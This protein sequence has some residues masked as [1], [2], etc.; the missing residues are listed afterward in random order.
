[1][2]SKILFLPAMTSTNAYA[3]QLLK[4]SILP[5]GTVIYTNYQTTGRGYFGNRWESE[6]GKN[7]LVSIILNP[8]FIKPEDQ[9]Y[10]SMA[11]SLG[12]CDF[13]WSYVNECTIKWPNDIYVKNDKIAGILVDSALSGDKI[14]YTVVGIGLNVNQEKFSKSVPN[15]ISMHLISGKNFNITDCLNKL[16]TILDKRYKQLI[17][18]DREPMKREYISKLFRYNEWTNFLDINGSF[19]GRIDTVTDDGCIVIERHDLKFCK[20]T[21]KEVEFII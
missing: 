11:I 20:Y 1:M 16:L 18:G 5:E 19:N 7:L 6:D 9:F 4:N 2:G 3:F 10:I 14:E 21:F 12:I 13:L 15:P 8:S 17:S